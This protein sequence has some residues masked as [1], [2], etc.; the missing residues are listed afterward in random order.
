MRS[1]VGPTCVCNSI[2]GG[3]R[4]L[5][6]L[7]TTLDIIASESYISEPRPGGYSPIF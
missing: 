3:R 7:L 4:A 5:A 2:G 6:L 1:K